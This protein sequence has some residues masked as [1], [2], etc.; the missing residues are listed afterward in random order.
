MQEFKKSDV[1]VSPLLEP[2][3]EDAAEQLFNWPDEGSLPVICMN[4]AVQAKELAHD[5][6]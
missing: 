3:L 1:D 5:A 6:A 2:L 4:I